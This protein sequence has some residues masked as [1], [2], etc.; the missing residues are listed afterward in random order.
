[1]DSR[2]AAALAGVSGEEHRLA[3]QVGEHSPGRHAAFGW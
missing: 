3:D 1:M 2:E